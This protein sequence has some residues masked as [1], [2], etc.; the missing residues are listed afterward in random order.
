[1]IGRALVSIAFT[2]NTQHGF[3]ETI[4]RN[5]EGKQRIEDLGHSQDLFRCT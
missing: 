1:M 5:M 4:D 3:F 2:C